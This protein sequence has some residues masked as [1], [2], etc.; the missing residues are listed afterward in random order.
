MS[1]TTRCP[2]AEASAA[3]QAYHDTEWGVPVHDDRLLFEVLI[4]EGAQAGLSWSTILQKRRR[5]REVFDGFDPATVAGYS[6]KKLERLLGD[7]GIVRNRLKIESA[8][9]SARAFIGVQAEFGSFDRYLW[10]FV[11]GAPLQNAWH[12]AEEVPVSTR[13]SDSYSRA[14]KARGFRFVGPTICYAYLQAVGVVNDHL[15]GC[16]RHPEVAS[17]A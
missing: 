4:L 15:T 13:L 11:D 17:L 6:R 7:P 3:E 14:L 1:V 16:F 9:I 10:G 12:V 2:W 5:Y 8:V